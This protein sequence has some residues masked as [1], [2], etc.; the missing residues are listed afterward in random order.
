MGKINRLGEASNVTTIVGETG[1]P[2]II[3]LIP[4]NEAK[5]EVVEYDEDGNPIE[6]DDSGNEPELNA[7]TDHGVGDQNN[8]A[9]ADPVPLTESPF[10]STP[11]GAQGEFKATGET[12]VAPAEQ[13]PVDKSAEEVKSWVGDDYVK[14]GRALDAEKAG[15]NRSGLVNWLEKVA[16]SR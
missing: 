8:P 14:A 9:N 7:H 10:V 13:P 11:E 12:E 3:D 5:T 1:E 15:R 4:E 6:R 2:Q 16:A